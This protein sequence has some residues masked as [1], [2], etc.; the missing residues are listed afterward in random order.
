MKGGVNVRSLPTTAAFIAEGVDP[1]LAGELSAYPN[2]AFMLSDLHTLSNDAFTGDGSVTVGYKPYLNAPG[3]DNLYGNAFI[4]YAMAKLYGAGAQNPG[5]AMGGPLLNSYRNI[6]GMGPQ[7]VAMFNG[8]TNFYRSDPTLVAT[9]LTAIIRASSVRPRS[10][11]MVKTDV[12]AL[13]NKVEDTKSF[14]TMEMPAIKV[15]SKEYFAG[16]GAGTSGTD[17]GVMPNG[18]VHSAPAIPLSALKIVTEGQ[19]SIP[20]TDTERAHVVDVR[21]HAITMNPN[22]DEAGNYIGPLMRT[23]REQAI[24]GVIGTTRDSYD[25]ARRVTIIENETAT[26][27]TAGRNGSTVLLSPSSFPIPSATR[28]GSMPAVLPYVPN[29]EVRCFYIFDHENDFE[30][31]E[32]WYAIP[33]IAPD[34]VTVKPFEFEPAGVKTT[35]LM[36]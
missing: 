21:T 15:V 10:M 9:L 25:A 2:M 34:S 3:M 30:V 31:L 5:A 23:R 27:E 14:E 33:V 11:V 18:V 7:G 20:Y 13:F 17:G 16:L 36:L 1:L 28:G 19:L 32:R 29:T 35:T 4:K 8:A 24:I 12:K 26:P 22:V 6:V